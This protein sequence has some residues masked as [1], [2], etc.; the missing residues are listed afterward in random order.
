[1]AFLQ[2]MFRMLES[3]NPHWKKEGAPKTEEGFFESAAYGKAQRALR[4]KEPLLL[5]GCRGVGKTTILRRCMA[6]LMAGGTPPEAVLYVNFDYP[7]IRYC[8][9]RAV[10]RAYREVYGEGEVF[11]FFDEIEFAGDWLSFLREE[12]G[13][14]CRVLAACSLLPEETGAVRLQRVQPFSFYEY[15]RAGDIK[16]P[17]LP[18]NLSPETLY[19]MEA[20]AQEELFC[21]LGGLQGAFEAYLETGGFPAA[22][23][24]A[25]CKKAAHDYL[26]G[27]VVDKMLARDIPLYYKIRSVEELE[28][29]FLYLC[30]QSGEL[31]NVEK[32]SKHCGIGRS[33]IERYLTH[34]ERAGMV[35]V[36]ESLPIHDRKSVSH[37][38]KV[39]I[40]DP[41][42]CNAALLF[43]QRQTGGAVLEGVL[44]RH[45]R[46]FF[47]EQKVEVG[48]Y[49]ESSR[50]KK[51]D[52]TVLY[53][54]GQYL[55]VNFAYQEKTTLRKTDALI[56]LSDNPL[57][58]YL[59]T[60]N[61][62]DYGLFEFHGTSVYKLPACAIAY[63]LGR[64]EY[65]NR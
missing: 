48:F 46:T 6:E 52:M 31:L 28:T 30:Y 49:R 51:I 27:H 39:Y 43:L 20:G 38:K 40:S 36:S 21:G 3:W 14:A 23:L 12:A 58:N 45:L 8:T 63:I 42:L 15:C 60:K 37:H 13:E 44:F 65:K 16:R 22:V 56:T 29:L 64:Y 10:L 18:E 1:M 24:H 26:R 57:P 5:Y 34:F 33:T 59:V 53:P 11:C 41:A 55:L 32:L 2:H 61:P 19:Q 50:G 4:D 7:L 62:G 35:S 17:V 9:P 25:S 54:D 47:D